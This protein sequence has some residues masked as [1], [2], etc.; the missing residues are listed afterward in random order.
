MS[1]DR[2]PVALVTNATD[3]AGRPA[4]DALV[5]AGFRVLA[6]DR[7]FADPTV[8]AGF[9]AAH[10][11]AE[12]LDAA[13]PADCV[14]H[15]LAMAG[16][17]DVIVSNDHHPARQ[18]AT[19]AAPLEELRTS[20]E[21]LVVDPFALV[22]AALPH[23]KARARGTIVMITSNR[24]RLPM[25]GGAIPDAARAAVNALVRS[26]AIELAPFNIAINAIAPNFLYSEA[27]Y[28]RAVFVD[29]PRGRAYIEANVPA[30]R[31]GKPEE[32]GEVIRFLATSRAA[33]L[34]GAIIDFSGGWPVGAPRPE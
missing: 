6:H 16:V 33:F 24:T 22:Q 2:T 18:V 13:E 14:A 26:L 1:S 21:R 31:L 28:P 3:F 10:P 23:L 30:G 5:G 17:I 8:W 34:T 19:E 12:R 4:V 9:S 25:P 32:I 29:D 27:Y 15:A 20:L 7:G 11:G